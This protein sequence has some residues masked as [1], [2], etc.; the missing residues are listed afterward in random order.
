VT[1][2]E[3][4][5]RIETAHGSVLVVPITDDSQALHPEEARLA[6]TFGPPRKRMFA[7]GRRA[8][9]RA[10]VDHGANA[11]SFALLS[12]DRGAPLVPAGFRG[13]VSHKDT[14]AV[15]LVRRSE[16]PDDAH[17]GVDV[18]I[19]RERTID[20]SRRV[21]TEEEI[22]EGAAADPVAFQAFVLRRFSMKEAI[23]KAI[24]PFLRRYVGFREVTIRGLARPFAVVGHFRETEPKLHIEVDRAEVET[25][26]GRL[27]VSTATAKLES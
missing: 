24:D 2:A 27:I 13:S 23:Y 3:F 6:E 8:L 22:R 19:D 17:V 15:A 16:S 11:E 18:E 5:L 20:V 12:N 10:L 9:R 25:K 14:V 26:P 1:E 21:L 7:A 4:E